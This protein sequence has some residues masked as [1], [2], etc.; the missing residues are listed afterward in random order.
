MQIRL[1]QAHDF[2]L[3]HLPEPCSA[4][5]LVV[6]EVFR[7]DRREPGREPMDQGDDYLHVL[8]KEPLV[9]VARD[10][11]PLRRDDL[12]L[13]QPLAGAFKQDACQVCGRRAVVRHGNNAPIAS[14]CH[15]RA[16]AWRLLSGRLPWPGRQ[17]ASA[18]DLER[19]AGAV[20]PIQLLR[21]VCGTLG[22]AVAAVHR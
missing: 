22:L 20:F 7:E 9:G 17:A 3:N 5:G 1:W 15:R 21:M 8:V 14:A 11:R 12:L 19:P 18:R 10:H 13:L 4:T 2:F 16:G 6:S